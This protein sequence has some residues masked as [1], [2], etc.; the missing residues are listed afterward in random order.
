MRHNLSTVLKHKTV[1]TSIAA[2][3]VHKKKTSQNNTNSL[4]D[5][6]AGK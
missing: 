1:C 4:S 6:R 5:L 2:V 3:T